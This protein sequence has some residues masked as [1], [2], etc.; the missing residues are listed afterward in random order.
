MSKK[1]FFILLFSLVDVYKTTAQKPENN[2]SLYIKK[3][4]YYSEVNNDSV[5]YFI[6][7]IK[8]SKNTCIK[9]EALG[10]AAYAYYR[11][12]NYQK[13]KKISLENLKII[14]S[15]LLTKSNEDCLLN[16]KIAFLNRLFWIEKNNENYNKA[17][18]YL[19][20]VEKVVNISPIKDQIHLRNKLGTILNKATIKNYLDMP[21][22][23]KNISLKALSEIKSAPLKNIKDDQFL[24]LFKANILNSLGNSFLILGKEKKNLALIDSASYYYDKAFAVTEHFI[25][26]HKDS[27]ILYDFLKTDVLMA[28]NDFENAII[29]INHYKKTA[30]GYDYK[31]HE[32]LNKAICFHNLNKSDS[33]LYFAS[34]LLRNKKEKCKRSNLI[35]LY[36]ILSKEY[37]KLHKL[38][39]AYKYSKLEIA[40]FEKAKK[41]KE[42]TFQLLY[43]NDFNE[44]K[45]LN[46][47]IIEQEEKNNT[48]SN[49]FIFSISILILSLF[50]FLFS[51]KKEKDLLLAEIETKNETQP[52]VE[53]NINQEFENEIILTI[54][55]MEKNLE[56][57]SPNFSI[58]ALADK[59][60]TNST[61]I[62][63]VFNKNKGE[64]FKQYYTKKK[65][66]YIIEKLKTDKK[67]RNYSIQSLAEEVGYSNASAFTRAFKKQMDTTPSAFLKDL[68]N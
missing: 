1:V 27:K 30:N 14:D 57:L 60:N 21:E 55:K 25:P 7:K 56:F 66:D 40:E 19:I 45:K 24:L 13:A 63:F 17:Y 61:Y 67:Y 50:Y 58:N 16:R 2:D 43:N 29:K 28:K 10:R 8:N 39:S 64:T 18:N 65:I 9:F 46:E 49:I 44:A 36:D 32:F 33:A 26:T 59:L 22:E 38:D 12:K 3:A 6:N 34:K 20:E 35:T 15:L 23:A 62:S 5:F 53:Y 37:F 31:H 41:N 47:L 68:E 4:I 52:K 48:K 42:K 51:K 54:D 11:K